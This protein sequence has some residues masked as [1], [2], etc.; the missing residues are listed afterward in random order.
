MVEITGRL[1]NWF[2]DPLFH[3]IWGNIY[4]DIHNRWTE[5]QKIHT[6]HIK[7]GD[8]INLKENPPVEGQIIKTLNSTYLLGK[9]QGDLKDNPE[10]KD[11]S[12]YYDPLTNTW[13]KK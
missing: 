1:E 8:R 4:E 11:F 3:C 5:G 2:Y 9:P 13:L 10:Y 12:H 6:S 7:T